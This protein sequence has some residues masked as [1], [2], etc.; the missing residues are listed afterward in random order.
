[1]IGVHTFTA[2]K[3]DPASAPDA[4]S[5]GRVGIDARLLGEAEGEGQSGDIRGSALASYVDGL[6]TVHAHDVMT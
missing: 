5:H 3:V 2:P 4:V 1:M 6:R